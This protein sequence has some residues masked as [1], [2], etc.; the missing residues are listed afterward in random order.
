M[1]YT[2]IA[3]EL[4]EIILLTFLIYTQAITV[5]APSRGGRPKGSK[6]RPKSRTT[7]QSTQRTNIQPTEK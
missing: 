4:L 5:K 6:N 3:L 1:N 2:E 7:V